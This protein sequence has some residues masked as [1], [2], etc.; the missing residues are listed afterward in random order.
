MISYKIEIFLLVLLIII[1]PICIKPLVVDF[2]MNYLPT[3]S[4]YSLEESI[5]KVVLDIDSY[6]YIVKDNYVYVLEY[7]SK[8]KKYVQEHYLY[9]GRTSGYVPT[10]LTYGTGNRVKRESINSN[11]NNIIYMLNVK[12]HNGNYII[13]FFY[14]TENNNIVNEKGNGFETIFL[15]EYSYFF[16]VIEDDYFDYEI[17]CSNDNEK[18]LIL[19]YNDIKEAFGS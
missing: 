12:K 1:L 19:N 10:Y 4:E 11:I 15:T 2:Y 18:F 16:D 5:D 7:T 6:E 17:Y 9:K 8:Y 3:N 13:E 14:K